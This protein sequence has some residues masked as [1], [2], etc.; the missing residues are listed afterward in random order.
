MLK[1]VLRKLPSLNAGEC[2]PFFRN[3][4]NFSREVAISLYKLK[5]NILRQFVNQHLSA[6]NAIM[7]QQFIVGGTDNRHKL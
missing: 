3:I 7:R 4:V 6:I 5:N 2:I 1:T